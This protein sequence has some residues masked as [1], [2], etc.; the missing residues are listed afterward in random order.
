MNSNNARPKPLFKSSKPGASFAFKP[1][2]TLSSTQEPDFFETQPPLRQENPTPATNNT[3]TNKPRL[4][5]TTA[6]EDIGAMVKERAPPKAPLQSI[7]PNGGREQS[8]DEDVIALMTGLASLK[9]QVHGGSGDAFALPGSSATGR[10][11]FG[12]PTKMVSS[13]K[14]R[15]DPFL[16]QKTRP[17]HHIDQSRVTGPK[18]T[19]YQDRKPPPMQMFSSNA[20]IAPPKKYGGEEFFTDPAKA[21]A[22]LKAL[23]EGGM[24]ED[25]DEGAAEEE[26]E[27]LKKLQE[28]PGSGN[29][30]GASSDANKETKKTDAT[31]VAKDG[32][33]DGLKVKLLPHQ[34]EGVQWMRGRELGP[35]K[36]GR[37][38][39]GG[40]LADD[41]G[42]G[43]TL[44]TI[45]LLLTNRKPEK[46]GSGW[47]KNFEKVEK[48]TLVVAPLALIRQWE[49]EIKDKVERSQGLK[50]CVHH[51]P[52]RTKRFQELALY[53]VVITTYQI[54]VSEHN[55]SS[56][57]E[58]GVKAG[59]FGLHWWR[60]VLDEAHTVKNRNAKAT[61]ACYALRSEYRWCLSG[62]PMQNNLDE[63]QSLVKFLRIS[64]YDDLKE[65]KAHIDLP[66]KN[67]K[68]HIAIRRL[69]SLLRC[70]MKRRTKEILKEAGALNPGGK[71]SA[72]GAAS[73]TGFKVTER[74]VVT[75]STELS[76][77]ERKFY[78]RLEARADRSIEAMMRGRVNYA[79]AL[80]L[81]LRLRQACN[82]PKLLEGKLDKDKDALTTDLSQKPQDTD[83]DVMADMFAG[84]GIESKTCNICGRGLNTLD[85]RLGR[86]ICTECHD[87]LAYFNSL[88]KEEKKKTFK[89]KKH[90]SKKDKSRKHVDGKTIEKEPEEEDVE[91][92]NKTTRRPR[93]RNAVLDSEDEEEAESTVKTARRP[94]N[95]ALDSEDEEAE[96]SWLVP[97]D[98]QTGLR[99]GKAG[100]EEDENA[101]GG[102]DWLGSDDSEDE[103]QSKTQDQ[104]NLSSFIID[105][106]AAKKE[107]GYQSVG[108]ASDGDDDSLLSVSALT[109]QMAAQT[110]D[111][112][113]DTSVADTSTADTTAADSSVADT[114][115]AD[116]PDSGASDSE[117]PDS[118]ASDSEDDSSILSSDDDD[119]DVRHSAYSAQPTQ[120]LASAKIRELTKILRAEVHEHKFIVFSQFTSMLD[121]VE[122]F[123]RKDG[124]RFVRYDGSMK[125]DER[126]ES[127]RSLR[128]DKRTRILLCSLKCGSLGLNLT[129]ATRV[130]ILEPFW[131]PFVEEQ[132]IDRVHRLTQTV[133]VIIYKLTVTKTVEERI[134][135]LQNKKRLLAE[136]AIEGSMK[137]GAFKLDLNELIN[138]FKPGQDDN[139]ALLGATD[140]GEVESIEDRGYRA[141]MMMK[142]KPTMARQ[143][144]EVYG[145]R[146]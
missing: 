20:P 76:P 74:K 91:S 71:P 16:R 138:L 58:G 97:E 117:A 118:E 51:G 34:V 44:Q 90:K 86:D 83:V 69:H 127:L 140:D 131:N 111:D 134:L 39:K 89:S 98:E 81:L 19:V 101:E 60:V 75:V 128:S 68:G 1:R 8:P 49:H 72:E 79:N 54:L 136:Q 40:I 105:D 112:A 67:G 109:K 46:D 64:P 31:K 62:T 124:F 45:S 10:P 63:L 104:S 102:G 42:L 4:N 11:A 132:A 139:H 21:S 5:D 9:G 123:L 18:P 144:S 73:S 125:N 65:W 80:T 55:H 120:L 107:K 99:L 145:R 59:C 26:T 95:L 22:D 137:K 113:Q 17:E 27:V 52:Q 130:V 121:L 142:K 126:E 32:T 110:L 35:I 48:T 78:K 6:L 96:G 84:M 43:K 116:T 25:D 41:M 53:D 13:R 50:V 3:S 88:E 29:E 94:R 143:E 33:V 106:E 115:T 36:R 70:F 85:T 122:P 12:H 47:K 87:D 28:S 103:E 23:L 146:W 37:V 61:K 93:N 92:P 108:D 24:D 38:P 114:T 119:D 30:G 133:D 57:A 15:A 141:S 14:Q 66:L 77:A 2:T 82:H 7:V 56:D 129:A 100:G 135:D